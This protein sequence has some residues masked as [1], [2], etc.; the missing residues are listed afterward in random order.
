MEVMAGYTLF[1]LRQHSIPQAESE[2]LL[3]VGPMNRRRQQEDAA[4]A[5]LRDEAG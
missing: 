3:G 4:A 1:P 5:V 2:A